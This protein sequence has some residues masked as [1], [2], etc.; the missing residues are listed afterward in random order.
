M[1]TLKIPSDNIWIVLGSTGCG[2][3][4][5][6]FQKTICL[7]EPCVYAR[8]VTTWNLS[9]CCYLFPSYPVGEEA[10]IVQPPVTDDRV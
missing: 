6:T 2:M 8:L 3:P 9:L 1:T 4:Y 7:S 5:D 10:T